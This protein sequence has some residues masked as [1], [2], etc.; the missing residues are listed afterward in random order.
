MVVWE[1]VFQ[2]VKQIENKINSSKRRPTSTRSD[3]LLFNKKSIIE[4]ILD[5]NKKI[6]F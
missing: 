2:D 6:D 1:E 4:T 5:N 3:E